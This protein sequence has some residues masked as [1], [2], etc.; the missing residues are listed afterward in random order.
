MAV[1]SVAVRLA[2]PLAAVGASPAQLTPAVAV[3]D[4]A[5]GSV[6][7]GAVTDAAH[8]PGA[9]RTL[10]LTLGKRRRSSQKSS[11]A[12]HTIATGYDQICIID[13]HVQSQGFEAKVGDGA[14]AGARAEAELFLPEMKSEIRGQRHLTGSRG[15]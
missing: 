6:I 2:G 15:R 1:L 5:G 13:R 9:Q 10:I 8:T 3:R 4:V 12:F 14:E 7:T 11:C